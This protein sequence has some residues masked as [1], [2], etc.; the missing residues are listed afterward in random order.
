MFL[1]IKELE[2]LYDG[3]Q[4]SLGV[5][6]SLEGLTLR[7]MPH[8]QPATNRAGIDVQLFVSETAS[9]LDCAQVVCMAKFPLA[10]PGSPRTW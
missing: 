6:T 3:L 8:M 2:S 1:Y 7:I 10:L 5:P 9:M 4:L